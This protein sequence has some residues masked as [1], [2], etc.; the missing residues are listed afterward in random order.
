MVRRPK[1]DR[2]QILPNPERLT[3][4]EIK[5]LWRQDQSITLDKLEI[6]DLWF[7]KLITD[8]TYIY[9]AIRIDFAEEAGEPFNV[10][11]FCQQW[12]TP[13]TCSRE[14]KN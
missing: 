8:K 11:E 9:L 1:E 4:G 2:H 6:M 10:N 5:S 7:R 12:E 13:Q 14:P 3:N